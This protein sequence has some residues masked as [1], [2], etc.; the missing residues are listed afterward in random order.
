MSKPPQN[1]IEQV[2]QPTSFLM[3]GV[4]A[5]FT[6]PGLAGTRVRSGQRGT[7]LV[8]PH[9]AGGRGAFVLAWPEVADFCAPTVHDT[10]L[11]EAVAALPTLTPRNV[12]QAARAVAGAGAAGHAAQE[13][14]EAARKRDK[15]RALSMNE[16]LLQMLLTQ[17][18]GTGCAL[19]ELHQRSTGVFQRLALSLGRPAAALAADVERLAV[20]YATIGLGREAGAYPCRQVL[21]AVE[22][23]RTELAGWTG[24][25]PDHV[26]PGVALVMSATETVVDLAR[27]S[28]ARA[29]ARADDLV[30]LL[31]EM[32]PDRPDPP[33]ILGELTRAEW[34]LDGWEAICLVWRIAAETGGYRAALAEMVLMVPV[35][36]QEAEGW[37]CPSLHEVER[38]HMR[39]M[40]PWLEDWRAGAALP[41]LIARNERIRAMAA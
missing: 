19:A 38:Q 4:A 23:L 8:M 9:R 35:I 15:Q 24:K 20:V 16:L 37:G 17:A 14:V 3:R 40:L 31:G 6:T 18:E 21:G 13:A 39:R 34:L 32:T 2:W 27:R 22:R 11:I 29:T 28:L 5:P 36:P 1:P 41:G 12:R 30:A 10:L 7:E 26:E 33:P 25:T